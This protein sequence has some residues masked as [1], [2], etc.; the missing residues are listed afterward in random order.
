MTVCDSKKKNKESCKSGQTERTEGINAIATHS[1]KSG[2]AFLPDILYVLKF[3]NVLK[4]VYKYA[5]IVSIFIEQ[6]HADV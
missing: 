6:I 1:H 2:L 3:Q 4:C 5:V